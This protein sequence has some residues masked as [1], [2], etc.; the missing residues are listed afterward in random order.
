MSKG[1]V[2]AT[3]VLPKNHVT[4]MVLGAIERTKPDEASCKDKFFR[5]L[6]E[7]IIPLDVYRVFHICMHDN[8]NIYIY[9]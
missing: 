1:F 6:H 5:A 3:S 7:P 9:I 2:A 8:I 4:S